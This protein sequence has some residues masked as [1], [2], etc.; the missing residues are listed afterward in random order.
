MYIHFDLPCDKQMQKKLFKKF[1]P[2]IKEWKRLGVVKRA[3]LT[4]HFLDPPRPDSLYLCLDIPAVKVENK[5]NLKLSPEQSKQIPSSIKL[6]ISEICHANHIKPKITDFHVEIEQE[7]RSKERR[8]EKYY[9]GAPIEDV[10]QFASV[11]TQ[12]AFEVHDH[13]EIDKEIWKTDEELLKFI[14]LRL[15]D[16]LGV[17]YKWMDLALHFVC[18]PLLIKDA[19]MY[20]PHLKRAIQIIIG[21]TRDEE[22]D[23]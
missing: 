5:Q 17:G 23:K 11:G 19:S 12:I 9:D 6:C 15:K 7:K 3:V 8:G 22:I 2:K 4:F 21:W 13:L 20:F 14:F 10:L 18:N 16:E 1:R